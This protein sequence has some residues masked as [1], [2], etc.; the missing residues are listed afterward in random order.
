MPRTRD[1]KRKPL[2]SG[3]TKPRATKKSASR[4]TKARKA[5]PASKAAAK[6]KRAA[7][8][9]QAAKARPA[10]KVKS[11]LRLD[12]FCGHE[13]FPVTDVKVYLADEDGARFLN[14]EIICGKAIEQSVPEEERF[15]QSAVSLE[16]W[17]PIPAVR[18]E[19]L[20]GTKV[21]VPWSRH[22]THDFWNYLCCY[23][24]EDVRDVN[25]E[26]VEARGA[27]CRAR[28]S[29]T[30]RDPNHYDGSKTDTKVAA[31]IWFTLVA[32]E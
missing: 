11:Q 30:T 19:A 12:R 3:K 8:A 23:E 18:P 20:A 13:I 14:L 27:E 7:P 4:G 10:E 22:E 2:S 29:G 15:Q 6:P 24:Q 1:K 28:V 31:E 21:H 32:G 26:F 17:I 9:K 25:V 16:V 5:R